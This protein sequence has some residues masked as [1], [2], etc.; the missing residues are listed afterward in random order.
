METIEKIKADYLEHLKRVQE[1]EAKEKELAQKLRMSESI[2]LNILN[3]LPL[4][5]FLE[6]RAGRTLFGNAE[7]LRV[8]G[9]E[10]D[11]L[12]G[13]TVFDFFPR[14]IA[15]INRADD[16]EIWRQR[17]LISKEVPVGFRGEER[18]MYTG[19]TIIRA[20]NEDFL[21]GFGLDITDR[22]AMEQ[23]LRES[24][25]KFRNVVDQAA[26]CFFLIGL[27]GEFVNVNSAAA[28]LLGYEQDKLLA[29]NARHIFG[30]LPQK[31]KKC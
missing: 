17:K 26:D 23:K 12:I 8:Q 22:V 24:E 2:K 15:E 5:I 1:L 20:E 25:E 14:H 31:W 10:L 28:E 4:N 11:E 18:V 7:V 9:M 6:D 3:A 13:K 21:L 30:I 29:M 19:K 16:L 27:N